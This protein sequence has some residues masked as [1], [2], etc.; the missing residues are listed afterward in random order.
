MDK[1]IYV[2]GFISGLLIY[3]LS[4][5]VVW[6]KSSSGHWGTIV[7]LGFLSMFSGL[8]GDTDLAKFLLAFSA[9]LLVFLLIKFLP[10]MLVRTGKK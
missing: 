8:T 10:A 1:T 2:L 3:S 6:R 5:F 9:P 4:A 7:S